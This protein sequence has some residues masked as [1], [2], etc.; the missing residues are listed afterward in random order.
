MSG[1]NERASGPV[2][3]SGFLIVP[4]HSGKEERGKNRDDFERKKGNGNV[5]NE[6]SKEGKTA[7]QR[8]EKSVPE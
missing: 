2:L 4:D 1:A 6:K 5:N 3:T 8:R 7:L